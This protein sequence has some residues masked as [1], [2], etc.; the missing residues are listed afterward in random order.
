MG[1][2]DAEQFALLLKKALGKRTAYAY[3]KEV[4]VSKAHIL[5]L[6]Q[7]KQVS[8]PGFGT[9][10]KL[11]SK[12]EN[13]VT[14]EDFLHAAGLLGT[15]ELLTLNGL[16]PSDLVSKTASDGITSIQELAAEVHCSDEYINQIGELA[17][18]MNKHNV[19]LDEVRR[20]IKIIKALNEK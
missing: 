1:N 13:G 6:L 4:G 12:A 5:R 15:P 8:P 2:F 3:A 7:Q 18:Q 16:N 11:A 10:E 17:L 20:L 9:I 14:Y 19:S